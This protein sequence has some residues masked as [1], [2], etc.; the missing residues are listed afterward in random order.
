MG[1]VISESGGSP[2]KHMAG[3]RGTGSQPRRQRANIRSLSREP[4]LRA[5]FPGE[6]ALT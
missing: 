2:E 1:W 3:L 6:V 4:G 5:A